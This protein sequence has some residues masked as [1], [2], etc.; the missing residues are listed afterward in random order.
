VNLAESKAFRALLNPPA[1]IRENEY[2]TLLA[3][4]LKLR[5]A[6]RMTI[7]PARLV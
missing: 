1:S 6:K 4:W 2:R 7:R 3:T 5:R